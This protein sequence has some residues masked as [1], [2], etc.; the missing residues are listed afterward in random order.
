MKLKR[1]KQDSLSE[2]ERVDIKIK[3]IDTLLKAIVPVVT[4]VFGLYIFQYNQN[5]LQLKS[6]ENHRWVKQIEI[7]SELV[8]SVSKV[9]SEIGLRQTVSVNVYSEYRA[10]YWRTLL[11]EDSSIVRKLNRFDNTLKIIKDTIIGGY[12][13]EAKHALIE[14]LESQGE[15]LIEGCRVSINE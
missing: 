8:E 6:Y 2:Y 7:K 15:E 1:S 11:F 5:T 10:M 14:V 4:V 3:Q 9:L 13:L 12:D